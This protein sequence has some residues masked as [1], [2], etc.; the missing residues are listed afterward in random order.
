MPEDSFL[1][2]IFSEEEIIC[3]GFEQSYPLKHLSKYVDSK[4]KT[5][6]IIRCNYWLHNGKYSIFCNDR[7]TR[8]AELRLRVWMQSCDAR[9]PR[10]SLLNYDQLID[11][12]L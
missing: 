9:A 3:D 7:A 12:L 8:R 5:N 1:Y 6:F 4:K 11:R 10:P 2:L